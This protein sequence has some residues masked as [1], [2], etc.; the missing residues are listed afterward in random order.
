MEWTNTSDKIPPKYYNENILFITYSKVFKTG[1]WD[2]VQFIDDSGVK[3]SA[4]NE[5]VCFINQN[6]L[7]PFDFDKQQAIVGEHE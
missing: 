6:D 4:Y 2:G 5:V 3:Y 7:L 1:F